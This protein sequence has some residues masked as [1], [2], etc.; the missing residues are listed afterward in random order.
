MYVLVWVASWKTTPGI[1]LIYMIVD[2][3]ELG[4]TISKVD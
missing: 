3:I 2:K 4:E 1:L